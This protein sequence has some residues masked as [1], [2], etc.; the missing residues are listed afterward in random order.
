MVDRN[1]AQTEYIDN[2][3]TALAK[4]TNPIDKFYL[5]EKLGN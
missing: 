4:T 1:H 3:Q 2:L 5:L